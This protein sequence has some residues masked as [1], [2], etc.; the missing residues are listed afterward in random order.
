MTRDVDVKI[1]VT[2]SIALVVFILFGAS[3]PEMHYN[4][5]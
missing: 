4:Y 1:R 3:N 2:I 5:N